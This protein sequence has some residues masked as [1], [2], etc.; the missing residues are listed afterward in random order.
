MQLNEMYDVIIVG[1]GPSGG[2]A[3][4]KLAEKGIKI[5]IIEKRKK[6]GEPVQCAEGLSL[7]ALKENDIKPEKD[8]I[9]REMK[10]A[11]LFTSSGYFMMFPVPGYIIKRNIFDQYLAE[12]AR[13]KGGEIR[14]SE[15]VISITK[16][17]NYFEVTSDKGKYYAKYIIL[18]CGPYEGIKGINFPKTRKIVAIEFR[19]KSNKI[20]DNYFHFHFGDE[21][22]P[23][24]GWVFFHGDVTGI[25]AGLYGR[26]NNLKPIEF[27]CKKYG[28]KINKR[29]KKI[30]GKIPFSKFPFPEDPEGIIRVGDAIGAVH[31]YTAGGIHGALSTAKIAAQIIIK[32][33]EKS[34]INKTYYEEIKKLPIFKDSLWNKQ[35]KLFKK[36]SKEWDEI[37]RLM[38]KRVYSK[39]PWGRA[40]FYLFLHPFSTFN[41]LF[42]LNLQKEFKLSENFS[43]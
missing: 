4:W 25:G 12:K 28:F 21:F 33:F 35:D 42:F 6:I 29:I 15:R 43:Y 11:K 20:D 5:L 26:G 13:E 34:K 30:A 16:R 27:L 23:F 14:T 36:T 32:N 37:G 7:F 24:Y 41:L 40:I 10:G 18:A 39:T 8:F 2:M 3:G 22:K 38:H 17:Q 1:A 19:F 31:P 9:V